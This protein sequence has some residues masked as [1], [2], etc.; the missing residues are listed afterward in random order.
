MKII[1]GLGNPGKEYQ[2][3]RHNVGFMVIDLL[4][5][6]LEI[7]DKWQK[8][9]NSLFLK[10]GELLLLKPQTYMNL[11]GRAVRKVID[12]YK[13]APQD[14]L[15]VHDDIDLEEGI[16]K[17]KNSGGDGGN[18]GIRSIIEHLG[19]KE[20]SRIKIGIGHPGDKDKV[21]DYV[22]SKYEP[23]QD[24]LLSAVSKIKE[25]LAR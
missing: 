10:S 17:L 4:V 3:T 6:E 15:I 2:R 1:T 25:W 7:A 5:K 24:T 12:F 22:L 20:F 16:L 18:R 9:F 13:I 19:T 8:K 23:Q 11:S 21:S 14:I